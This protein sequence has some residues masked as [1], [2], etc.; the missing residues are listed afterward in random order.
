[1][2]TAAEARENGTILSCRQTAGHN[3]SLISNQKI[4][5]SEKLWI[6]LGRVTDAL[7][8]ILQRKLV[9]PSAQEVR[10]YSW[11]SQCASERTVLLCFWGLAPHYDVQCPTFLQLFDRAHNEAN[12]HKLKKEKKK[13]AWGQLLLFSC[14]SAHRSQLLSGSALQFFV[15]RVT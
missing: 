6:W 15:H 4:L 1:M 10:E 9:Y 5:D 13:S 7:S 11:F 2:F 12:L 8:H 14:S 3:A